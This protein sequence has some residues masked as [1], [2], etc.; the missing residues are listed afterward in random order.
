MQAGMNLLLRALLTGIEDVARAKGVKT[1]RVATKRNARGELVV[2][3]IIGDVDGPVGPMST[4][5]TS[6]E[7]ASRELRRRARE[8]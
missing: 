8:R 6:S 3:L 1:F 2:A 4:E 5:G 7:R